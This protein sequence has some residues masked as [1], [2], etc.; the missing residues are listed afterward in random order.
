MIPIEFNK[1]KQFAEE[2]NKRI[3]YHQTGVILEVYYI[4]EGVIIMSFINV[5]EIE[6]KE[7]F[8]GQQI[9]LGATKMLFSIKLNN[10]S[11]KGIRD[12]GTLPEIIA[13]NATDELENKDIQ[14]EGVKE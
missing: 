9:F 10:D 4:T 11:Q 2:N 12:I 5:Q 7:T 3:Y 8:F 6:D 13:E 14:K 1:F